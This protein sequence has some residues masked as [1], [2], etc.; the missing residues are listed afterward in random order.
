MVVN[1]DGENKF[2]GEGFILHVNVAPSLLHNKKFISTC[3]RVA[4]KITC[5]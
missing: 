3:I 4:K 2:N 1:F 5:H